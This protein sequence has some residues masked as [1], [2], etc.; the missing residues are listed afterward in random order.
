VS[1]CG[2]PDWRHSGVLA[3]ALVAFAVDHLRENL[4]PILGGPAVVPRQDTG[5]VDVLDR[6][7]PAAPVASPQAEAD[8]E[9]APPESKAATPPPAA[10]QVKRPGRLKKE[11]PAREKVESLE[12][13]VGSV[14]GGVVGGK[15]ATTVTRSSAVAEV[16]RQ[17]V[18]Q[19][20]PGI[21]A[22][23]W[24]DVPLRWS[25]PVLQNQ[26]VRLWL[27]SPWVNRVLAFLRVGL[28]AFLALWLLVGS[29][30]W[31][32]PRLGRCVVRCRRCWRS[33]SPVRRA[34]TATTSRATSGWRSSGRCSSAPRCA[35]DCASA[36]RGLLEVEPGAIRLRL[37]LEASAPVAVPLPGGG[38]GWTP[39]QVVVDGRPAPAA[40]HPGTTWLVLTPGVHTVVPGAPRR[41]HRAG[42]ARTGPR[43]LEVRARGW[44]VDGV[45][46]TVGPNRRSS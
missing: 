35:P 5:E 24:Q 25:G 29:G 22:W 38:E 8:E 46:E 16:D 13:L 40:A 10:E 31:S 7:V 4:Y 45:R 20:G 28:L 17:A 41:R 37:E 33:C 30:T 19:T 34:P 11:A 3:I 9:A 14:A 42:P 39:E 12:G 6:R 26:T 27:F 44:K 2:S 43:H 15:A 21:P 23:R 1:R 32:P 18:V 36:G